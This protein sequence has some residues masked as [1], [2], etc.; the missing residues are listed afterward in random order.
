MRIDKPLVIV[1]RIRIALEWSNIHRRTGNTRIS[2]K[3]EFFFARLKC[4]WEIVVVAR[5][6]CGI[7]NRI[8]AFWRTIG[9]KLQLSC[10]KD[11]TRLVCSF[12]LF[13]VCKQ[14]IRI[15]VKETIMKVTCLVLWY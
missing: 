9:V 4:R 6:V 7:D 1:G 12:Y 5:C 11:T 8:A 10:L 15:K 13:E 14:I 3:V 2:A